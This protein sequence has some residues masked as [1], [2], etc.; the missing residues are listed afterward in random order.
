M[1]KELGVV[2]RIT[3]SPRLQEFFDICK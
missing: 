1:R 3:N 2:Y